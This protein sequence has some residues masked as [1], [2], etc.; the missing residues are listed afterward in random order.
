MIDVQ[1]I[2]FVCPPDK[3]SKSAVSALKEDAERNKE[4]LKPGKSGS[5]KKRFKKR[6]P[7]GKNG[8]N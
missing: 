3:N 4:L 5:T 1:N 8:M 6:R 7:K 2:E